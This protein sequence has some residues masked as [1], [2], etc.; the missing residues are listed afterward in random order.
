MMDRI[1]QVRALQAKLKIITPKEKITLYPKK[2][3]GSAMGGFS[4]L[5]GMRHR[6]T[7]ASEQR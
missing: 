7:V 2:I 1:D 4:S 5:S 3:E 6:M